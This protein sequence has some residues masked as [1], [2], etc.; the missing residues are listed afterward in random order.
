MSH[1][2]PPAPT[3][4]PTGSG[5]QAPP[6]GSPRR[7]V[8]RTDD[9][10]IAG[11][12][13]GLADYLNID[14]VIIRVLFVVLAFAGG[15]GI[16]AYVALWILTPEADGPAPIRD[17]DD[18]GI[19]FWVAIGLLV[20]GG[21]ALIGAIMPP[22]SGMIWPLLLIGAGVALWRSDQVRNPVARSTT[23][24][25]TTAPPPPPPPPPP[26]PPRRQPRAP[27]PHRAQRRH[28]PQARRPAPPTRT[29][30][31]HPWPPT[32]TP[33]NGSPRRWHPLPR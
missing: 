27:P 18:R 14:P 19:V 25:P 30:R 16:L 6:P 4:S 8:R 33:R 13:S 20:L 28:P 23:A 3:D 1:Q 12:A 5:T 9:R 21:I 17:I 10:V 26:H 2:P 22:L 31:P 32:P 7:L 29:R 11:V 24:W 15:G